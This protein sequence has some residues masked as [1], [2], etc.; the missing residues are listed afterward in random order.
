MT[1][2]ETTPDP[3][4]E[5]ATEVTEAPAEKP[6][7]KK[8]A[9]YTVSTVDRG[10]CKMRLEGAGFPVLSSESVTMGETEVNAARDAADRCGVELNIIKEG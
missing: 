3:T 6:V 1:M 10:V 2:S 9:T 8:T 5:V 4:P 7:K